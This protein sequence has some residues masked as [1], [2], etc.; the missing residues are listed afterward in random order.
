MQ[1]ESALITF[2]ILQQLLKSYTNYVTSIP[3]ASLMTS[4]IQ[5][6]NIRK[7]ETKI[8][9]LPLVSID[10]FHPLGALWET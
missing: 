2:A 3:P 1:T 8:W 10:M 4:N 5:K 7:T 9:I 6:H